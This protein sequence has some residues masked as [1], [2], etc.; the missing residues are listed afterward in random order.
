MLKE[1]VE[2]STKLEKAGIY[3]LVNEGERKLD[4]PVMVIPVNDGM[5][6]IKSDDIY[7]VFD[8]TEEDTD[9]NG[10]TVKNEFV[11]LDGKKMPWKEINNG[12]E[13]LLTLKKLSNETKEWQNILKSLSLYTKKPSNDSKGNKSIGSNKG[14]NSYN[15]LIFEGKFVGGIFDSNKNF[16]KKFTNT[17]KQ[18]NIPKGLP[19]D[20]DQEIRQIYL[21]L[22][23][24]IGA[25]ENCSNISNT[26]DKLKKVISIHDEKKDE[27]K[28]PTKSMFVVFK[29]PESFYKTKNNYIYWYEKYLSKKIF[30]EDKPARYLK[31]KCFSCNRENVSIYAPN[32]FHNFDSGKPFLKHRSRYIDYNIEICETCSLDMYK[33]Q[34]Y[35]LNKL[36]VTLFPLFINT[37]DRENVINFFKK[38]GKV[39]KKGFKEIVQEVYK[40]SSNEELDFYLIIYNRGER[41]LAFDYITGF[42]FKMY[43]QNIFAI[44]SLI[45]KY[46]FAYQLEKNYFTE[47]VDTGSHQLN[48]LIY[49]YRQQLFDYFYRAKYA[50]LSQKILADMYFDSLKVRLREFFDKKNTYYH[51]RDM[52]DVYFDFDNIFSKKETKMETVERI[53]KEEKIKN[54]ES[55]AYYAGQIAYYLLNQSKSS[56]KTHAMIEPFINMNNFGLLA[57]RIKELFNSYKHAIP[58][59]AKRFNEM[60]SEMWGF[61]YDNKEEKFTKDLKT[62][63]YAGYFNS[64]ENIF[65]ASSKEGEK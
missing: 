18:T 3:E 15:L 39:A 9:E 28:Y 17:Y 57:E 24:S 23:E 63:F 6:N 21:S 5:T 37:K 19:D 49:K 50:G 38:E 43:G 13:K 32:A 31:G 20:L 30:V 58:L 47:G 7:F 65:Y 25:E 41:I 11:T 14:T 22:F 59:N 26:I 29:F 2:F 56:E 62:L 1:I 36:K 4:K 42:K 52:S 60:F 40:N 8:I 48:I 55:F 46:F 54:K 53:K 27:L 44:E 51:L 12:G 35:F 33:F 16:Q 10:V 34:E 61:L 45:N 64:N